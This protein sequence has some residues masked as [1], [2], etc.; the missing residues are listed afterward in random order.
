[1]KERGCDSNFRALVP[2]RR[3]IIGDLDYFLLDDLRSKYLEFCIKE[4]GCLNS[5]KISKPRQML[6]KLA[7][8]RARY[9][10]LLHPLSRHR[11]ESRIT[12]DELRAA[13]RNCP[14]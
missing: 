4:I 1:M 10:R 8:F 6:E 14:C 2:L 3:G 12:C 7:K 5:L 13:S 11:Q 9:R